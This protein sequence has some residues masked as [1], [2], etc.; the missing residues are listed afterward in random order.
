M[1]RKFKIK[2]IVKGG[3]LTHV[4]A[5]NPAPA[6]D[7]K[8]NK[9]QD[10]RNRAGGGA[11]GSNV[12]KWAALVDQFKERQNPESEINCTNPLVAK[13]LKGDLTV[14]QIN[15]DPIG[16]LELAAIKMMDQNGGNPVA[17]SKLDKSMDVME[18]VGMQERIM[19]QRLSYDTGLNDIDNP[20]GINGNTPTGQAIAKTQNDPLPTDSYRSAGEIEEAKRQTRVQKQDRQR[21]WYEP[22]VDAPLPWYLR[23]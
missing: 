16:A 23:K 7:S 4:G 3:V 2:N 18:L 1:A 22:N 15:A 6:V 17:Y 20:L 19:R 8:P 11:A 5:E 10:A 12:A 13:I 14:S 21:E 9:V